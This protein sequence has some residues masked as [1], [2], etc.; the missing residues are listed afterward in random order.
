MGLD[1]RK[2]HGGHLGWPARSVRR[3]GNARCRKRT[4]M[5]IWHGQLD[6][7]QRPSLALWGKGLRCQQHFRLSQ[8]PLGVQSIHEPMGVDGRKQ[9]GAQLWQWPARCVRH[10]GNACR[11]KYPRRPICS[12]KLDRQQWPSLAHWGIWSW[13]QRQWWPSQRPLGIESY[14]EPMGVDGRKQ[15]GQPV[16]RVRHI[17]NARRRKHPRKPRGLR[18]LD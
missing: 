3:V 8:R 17:G 5:P 10:V 9:H 14:H 7:Q 13:C 6:R 18:E 12:N 11:W 4:R 15:H 2:Q 1:G 16:W